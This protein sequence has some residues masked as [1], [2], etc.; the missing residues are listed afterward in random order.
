MIHA[1]D[2]RY[3]V[4][5]LLFQPHLRVAGDRQAASEARDG[6]HVDGLISD[7]DPRAG[8]AVGID[9]RGGVDDHRKSDAANQAARIGQHIELRQGV[10]ARESAIRRRGGV[11]GCLHHRYASRILSGDDGVGIETEI[12]RAHE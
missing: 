4:S 8:G 2:F 11:C 1:G 12:D 5:W 3:W 10:V 9:E 6:N 7:V